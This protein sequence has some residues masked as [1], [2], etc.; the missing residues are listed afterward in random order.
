MM[1]KT[2]RRILEL[3]PLYSFDNTPEMQE[4]HQLVCHVLADEIRQQS[5][6]LSTA[7]GRFGTD[8]MVDASD[9]MGRKT[10]LPW[11][12]FCSEEMSPRPTQGFRSAL[13]FSTDG[14]ALHVTVGC[15]SSHLQSGFFRRLPASELDARTAWARR[16][17]EEDRGSLE[18]FQDPP[19]FGAR[20]PLPRSFE[21]ATAVSKRIAVD[22]LDV[23][24]IET[25]LFDA[26]EFLRIIY[27][28]Q[29]DGGDVSPADFD[30]LEIDRKLK[31]RFRRKGQGH[32]LSAERRVLVE[33]RAM[34]LVHEWLTRKGYDARDT[35][36]SRPYDFEAK[37]GKEVLKV[38]VK[39]TT[40]DTTD[41][42][43][44]T[45][46]EV[47][48]HRKEKGN[49]ALFVVRRIRLV[50]RDG[51]TVAVGGHVEDLV[52][53]DIDECLVVPTAFRVER[54]RRQSSQDGGIP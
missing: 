10:E 22:D 33:R 42:L 11:V 3:Q 12:R 8:L 14:S 28:A 45:R 1:R 27:Q 49:T 6:R 2:I 47:E 24:D 18:P 46:N 20:R 38:E 40:S 13:H 35:S 31:P 7:L 52:G 16:T 34:E 50:D 9:G 48:L 29:C 21:R 41:A 44:M 15:G 36:A 23:T 32:G 37:K 25:V 53:W 51:D 54:P 5:T 17:I 19:D 43:L 39:G 4:R 30:E 26:A